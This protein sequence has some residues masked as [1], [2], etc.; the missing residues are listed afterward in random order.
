MFEPAGGNGDSVSGGGGDASLA[1]PVGVLWGAAWGAGR[2]TECGG[3]GCGRGCG[4]GLGRGLG[5]GCGDR[6]GGRCGGGRFL[7]TAACHGTRQ[8]SRCLTQ[9]STSV[10][11]HTRVGHAEL[12]SVLQ[13]LGLYAPQ[14]RLPPRRTIWC[15][16]DDVHSVAPALVRRSV[17]APKWRRQ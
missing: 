14:T 1:M 13:G 12:G 8:Q 16:V 10:S 3:R 6:C 17:W 11:R 4:R 15:M 2:G 7:V 5:R 9:H